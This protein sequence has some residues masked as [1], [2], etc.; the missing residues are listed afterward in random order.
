MSGRVRGPGRA[1]ATDS[2]WAG[3]WRAADLGLLG[4]LV[5]VGS[6]LLIP[7]YGSAAPVLAAAAGAVVAAGTLVLADRFRL[8]WWAAVPVI[9]VG[10]LFVGSLIVAPDLRSFR[11]LPSAAGMVVVLRGSIGGWRELLTVAAP[12]GTAGALLVP[13]MLIGA[14]ATALA[15]ATLTTRRPTL[16]LLFPAAALITFALFGDRA[17]GSTTTVAVV[18]PVVVA[19]MSWTV[20][21]G[22]RVRRRAVARAGGGSA[23]SD[24]GSPGSG[25]AVTRRSLA[26]RRVAISVAVLAVAALVGSLAATAGTPERTALR[27]LVE[28]PLNPTSVSSPLSTFRTYTKDDADV[29]Q[30]SVSGLPSG[31]R[32][33]LATL[34]SYDGRQFVVSDTGGPFVR[35]GRQ[36]PGA[37]SGPT[38][39]VDVVVQNYPGPFLP[40]PGQLTQLDFAGPRAPTLADD[41]R[42]SEA[43][44]TGLLP[45]GW[46]PGDQ[47]TV[48]APV[49]AQ[50]APA[51]LANARPLAVPMPSSAAVPDLLR[52]AANRYVAGVTG[53]GAQVEAIRAGLA[54]EGL[55]SHGGQGEQRSAAGHGLDRMTAMITARPMVG[56]QEQYAALMALMVR[57]MGLPARVAVGF[58]PPAQGSDG[59]S[60]RTSAGT[61]GG[62]P[63][64]SVEL[65]GRD[66]TAWVEVPFERY[67]WVAFDPTPSPDKPVA[68]TE[69]QS[70]TERRAVTVEV[71]PALP[72]APPE[73]VGAENAN[74]RPD[75]PEPAAPAAANSG[76]PGLL[77]TILGWLAL[78]LLVLALPIVAILGRKAVRRR[79]RRHA[80]RATDQITGGWQELLDT[81]VDVGYRPVPWHTRAETAADLQ[82]GGT[83]Q[84]D[85]LAPAADAAEFAPGPV[86]PERA[87]GYW[88]EVDDRSAE[89]LGALPWAR[90][91]RARLSLAS[92]RRADQLRRRGSIR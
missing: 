88:R 85:W 66:I 54:A 31:A 50:P 21:V 72:Q 52:S 36:R 32:L 87:R 11:V 73:P 76:L 18:V 34:D 70:P 38:A 20:W 57:S 74:Q 43:A 7:A 44:G 1:R 80:E 46:Q 4:V 55:F 69:Q 78:V 14:V 13:P 61:N 28:V 86:Q 77:L 48:Q 15:G 3:W 67:G 91:W 40:L 10:V 12:T 16:A 2:G 6:T 53:A 56:D 83:L 19:G 47:Y 37:D 27:E 81:A 22:A 64:G 30:L 59:A 42:Y 79:S 90:R 24:T 26:A 62:D 63:S 60:A 45:G 82:A 29:V 17:V 39:I 68:D 51:D 75:V 9:G 71:P 65:R 33:R 23:R 58:Q 25:V 92:L 84:V 35:I 49:P 89:L 41:L 8:P 5:V